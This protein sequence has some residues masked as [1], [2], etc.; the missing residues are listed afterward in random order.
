[1]QHCERVADPGINK[2]MK[3]GNI[4]RVESGVRRKRRGGRNR[5]Q[6]NFIG[7]PMENMGNR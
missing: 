6:R 2:K 4:K 3:V 5:L 1:M 7:I